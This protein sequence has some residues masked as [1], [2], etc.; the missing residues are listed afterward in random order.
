MRW[1]GSVN[2]VALRGHDVM[3][4]IGHEIFS[5][6]LESLILAQSERWRQA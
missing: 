3:N 5:L 1:N 2:S 4:V 6:E